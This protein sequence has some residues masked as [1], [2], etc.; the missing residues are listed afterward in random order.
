MQLT[1]QTHFLNIVPSKLARST[2]ICIFCGNECH[3][4]T[5]FPQPC[6]LKQSQFTFT[7]GLKFD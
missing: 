2:K 4:Q 5:F 3:I 1:L 7:A 6:T